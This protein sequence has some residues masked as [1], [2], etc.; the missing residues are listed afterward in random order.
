MGSGE[1]TSLNDLFRTMA[2][3]LEADMEPDY[4]SL[5]PG[6][7]RHSLAS[8]ERAEQLLGHRPSV[9]WRTGL[10]RTLDW[11]RQSLRLGA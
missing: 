7:V 9:D 8:T 4:A 5:R 2:E 6:D 10:A 11:Y 3:L 1:R